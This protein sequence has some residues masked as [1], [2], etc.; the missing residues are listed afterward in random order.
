MLVKRRRAVRP[1]GH[2]C[3]PPALNRHLVKPRFPESF[4]YKV[5]E[6]RD[7]QDQNLIRIFPESVALQH[8]RFKLMEGF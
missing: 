6:I 2:V 3:E 5:L 7:A 8:L 4:N 1:V